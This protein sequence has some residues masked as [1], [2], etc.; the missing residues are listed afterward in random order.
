MKFLLTISTRVYF[1][2]EKNEVKTLHSLL[3]TAELQEMDRS[4]L[5]H[6]LTNHKEMHAQGTRIIVSG[7]GCFVY[8]SD[9][10]RFLDALAGLWCVVVGY[11]RTGEWFASQLWDL[12]P[13]LMTTAKALTSGY[14]PLS[15]LFVSDEI[16]Q[17]IVQGGLFSHVYT[18]SGHPVCAAA[19]LANLEI[20]ERENLI[21]RTRNITGP[22]FGKKLRE[23]ESHPAVGEVRGVGLIG[24]IELLSRDGRQPP[25]APP[26][27]GPKAWAMFRE[28]GLLLRVLGDTVAL[29]P[30]LIIN[31]S[32]IDYLFSTITR[33][34][35][36]LWDS[37]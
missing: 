13:D 8:D 33:V 19:A 31:H 6:P 18:Y 20:M 10:R 16:A 15:A 26:K 17:A 12:D 2:A 34:L 4:H 3:T 35:D 27:F 36:R 21:P 5:L 28:E 1:T 30:P 7:E 24:A 32:E 22:Y 29:C 37:A 25:G 9:G 23:L 14:L 11:G